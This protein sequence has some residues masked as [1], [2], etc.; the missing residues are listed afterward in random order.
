M[1]YCEI[2]VPSHSDTINNSSESVNNSSESVPSH[3]DT[4]NNASKPISAAKDCIDIP[5][6]EMLELS[7]TH[8]F[9]THKY[10]VTLSVHYVLLRVGTDS[11]ISR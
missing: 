8:A 3:S 6:S 9:V 7:L 4:I 11:K 5:M 1:R 10:P 2:A